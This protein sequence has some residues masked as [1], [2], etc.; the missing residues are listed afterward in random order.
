MLNKVSDKWITPTGI[1]IVAG[2]IIW[3][4]QLNFNAIDNAKEIGSLQATQSTLAKTQID[5]A[6]T[7]QRAVAIQES[8]FQQVESMYKQHSQFEQFI[9]QRE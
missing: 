9:Y 2:L 1:A 3:L 8:L 5:M 4:V 6:L 7:L